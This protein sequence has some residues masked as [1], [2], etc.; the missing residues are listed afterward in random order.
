VKPVKPVTVRFE[1]TEREFAEGL[2]SITRRQPTFWL[3]P[4]MGAVT[5]SYGLTSGEGVA[6][7]WGTVLLILAGVFLV[8]VPR[9]R[10]RQSSH[11]AVEQEHTFSE[12]RIAVRAAG[13]QG[14]LPWDFYVQVVETP[15]AYVLMRNRKQGNFIPRRAFSSPDD[16]ERFRQL[17]ASK[18]LRVSGRP[19]LP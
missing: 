6:V 18:A 12:E 3:G 4:V 9:L 7:V 5:L 1:L 11:L 13:Q 15:R 10:W 19:P 2:G 14:E 17:L 16:E 8:L